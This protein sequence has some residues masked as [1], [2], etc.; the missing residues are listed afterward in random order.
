MIIALIG[1]P[2]SGK[3]TLANEIQKK[4]YIYDG[5]SYPIIDGDEI[6][7]IFNNKDFSKDGRI[8]NLN[9]I[10][11]I[12]TFLEDKYDITIVS[13]VYPYKEAREYFES[14]NPNVIWVYLIYEGERGRE[15]FHVKDFDIPDFEVRN[16][17]T[18]NTSKNEINE[19]AQKILSFCWKVSDLTRR[20]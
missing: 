13:A 4:L 19:S 8:R 3:T 15:S 20:S 9:R 7:R 12:A 17:I 6:R 11:D 10:S 2:H 16:S 1:Q 14:I 5:C 18:I